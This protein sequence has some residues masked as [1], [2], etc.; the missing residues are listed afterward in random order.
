MKRFEGIISVSAI[1]LLIFSGIS[2]V[3]AESVDVLGEIKS[4]GKVFIA[5]SNGGWLPAKASYP[6]LEN[7]GI[8][9][10]DGTAALYFRDGS[11]ADVSKNSIASVRGSGSDFSI[12]LSRGVIAFNMTSMATLSVLTP[13][14]TV[15]VNVKNSP[16]QKVSLSKERVLGAVAVSEKGTEVRSISGRIVV[17]V[18]AGENRMISTGESVFIGADSSVRVYKTQAVPQS[19]DDNKEVGAFWL[20]GGKGIEYGILATI[21]VTTGTAFALGSHWNGNGEG[22]LASPSG[23]S[24][25]I[26]KR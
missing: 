19:D 14:S 11:R 21:G 2:G 18:P 20:T 9:T 8:K 22:K 10:E 7:T 25:V 6:M 16:V 4:T 17:S 15:S 23:F 5:S 24:D 12:S 3:Y 1:M 13:A 26:F